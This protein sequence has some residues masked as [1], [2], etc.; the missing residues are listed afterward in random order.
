MSALTAMPLLDYRVLI[1]KN[2]Q[3]IGFMPWQLQI[4][5]LKDRLQR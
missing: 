5:I 4:L 3:I 1:G 2:Q